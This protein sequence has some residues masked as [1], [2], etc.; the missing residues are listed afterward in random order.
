[1][2]KLPFVLTL[3]DWKFACNNVFAVPDNAAIEMNRKNIE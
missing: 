1:M 2:Q 3:L